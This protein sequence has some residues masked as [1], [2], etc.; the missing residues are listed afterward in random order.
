M[1]PNPS[2]CCLFSG[3]CQ[4]CEPLW[5][6]GGGPLDPSYVSLRS[7]LKKK[8]KNC[9]CQAE[10]DVKR[11]S[12]VQDTVVRDS[13]SKVSCSHLIYGRGFFTLPS[14]PSLQKKTKHE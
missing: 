10:M 14:K 6:R 13:R 5:D 2:A 12:P 3:F 8:K 1:K 11:K 7:H 4:M 9:P